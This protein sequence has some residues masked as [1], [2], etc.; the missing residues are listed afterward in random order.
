MSS[1]VS[2]NL[3]VSST[4]PWNKQVTGIKAW[5]QSIASPLYPVVTVGRLSLVNNSGLSLYRGRVGSGLALLPVFTVVVIGS[6]WSSLS[7]VPRRLNP[8]SVLSLETLENG[9]IVA[10]KRPVIGAS[11]RIVSDFENEVKL[12]SNVHHRNLIRLLGFCSSPDLLLVYEY[13]AHSSLD[14]FFFVG[15]ARGFA[16]LHEDFH[17]C[18]IHRDIK[19]SNIR[20]D[21]DFQPKIVD[22]GLARL[23][24]ENQSHLSTKFAFTFYGV[25]VLEII[26]GRKSTDQSKDADEYLLKQAWKPYEND[27]HKDLVDETR[28]PRSAKSPQHGST[29]SNATASI[30]QLSA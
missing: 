9:K 8:Q 17:V 21:D 27:M 14:K 12:I 7:D 25:V 16:Y 22:F 4:P 24:P 29:A 15:T 23:L 6:S 3:F 5:S 20:L 28:D 13:M 30:S 2:A 1:R 11:R 26:S 18:I 19:P 10:V